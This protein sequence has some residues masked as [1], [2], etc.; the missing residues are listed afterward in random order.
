MLAIMKINHTTRVLGFFHKD[1]HFFSHQQFF[2]QFV[3]EMKIFF[4]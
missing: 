1:K 3:G 4:K 2:R